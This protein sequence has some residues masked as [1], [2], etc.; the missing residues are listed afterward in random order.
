MWD[1]GCS[2]SSQKAA[3]S[4]RAHLQVFPCTVSQLHTAAQLSND[5][6][7]VWDFELNQVSIV[8]IV[9]GFAPFLTNVQYL[10]DDMTGPPMNVKL[11]ITMEDC[12]PASAS[13]GS[14]VKV[15]GS[16]R[17]HAGQ[18][19]LLAMNI[20]CVSDL[21][22]ISSHMLEVVHAHLHLSR[23]VFDVNMNSTVVPRPDWS[24]GVHLQAGLSTVQDQ[25]LHLIR[26]FS[27]HDEGIALSYLRTQL[28][29]ISMTDIRSSLE[30]LL[31][32]GHIFYTIDENHF[33]S[34]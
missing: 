17:T 7:S 20:R 25:V 8:G 12:L 23:K 19:S 1:P 4:K 18:R 13:P 3:P 30:F 2:H 33:K 31:N 6:F 16:L 28:D 9:R 32:E 29:H 27:V 24:S 26:V 10:V 5:C 22:E 15:I 21:N 14:Y 34:A 11:W